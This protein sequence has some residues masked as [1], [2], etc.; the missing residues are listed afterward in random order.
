MEYSRVMSA[1]RRRRWAILFAVTAC[2]VL[3]FFGSTRL[4]REYLATATLMAQD[5]AMEPVSVLA[6]PIEADQE[7]D[8]LNGRQDRIKTVAAVLSSPA[9]VSKVIR[10]LNIS[11]TPA[12]VQERMEVKEVTSQVLRV[13]VRDANPAL[14]VEMVNRF[15]NTFVDYYGDLRSRDARSQ[16]ALLERERA[17]ADRDVRMAAERLERFKR[18]DNISSLTDQTRVALEQARLTE[19]ERNK[20]PSLRAPPPLARSG[21]APP[22][23]SCWS[24]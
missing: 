4:G 6:K 8:D 20:A 17:A 18:R 22:R 5:E 15:V 12:R 13:T 2:T 21:R 11:T 16:L 19:Q 14:A 1:L 9:V 10:E 3:T 24:G 7:R 23:R